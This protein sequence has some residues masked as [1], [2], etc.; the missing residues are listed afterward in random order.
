MEDELNIPNIA[1][2]ELVDDIRAWA[3]YHE[4][5]EKIEEKRRKTA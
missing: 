2:I 1:S 4:L 3:Y 5:K